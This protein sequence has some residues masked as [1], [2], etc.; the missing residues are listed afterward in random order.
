MTP[1]IEF[2]LLF[3]ILG[4]LILSWGAYFE[5]DVYVIFQQA[6]ALGM[7]QLKA[8]AGWKACPTSPLYML[9]LALPAALH[10]AI[11]QVALLLSVLGWTLSA[12]SL[13]RL[14]PSRA[15]AYLSVLLLITSPLIVTTLG[16]EAAWMA[17][18]TT[19]ALYAFDK[20]HEIL[21]ALALAGLLAL[22][23]NIVTVSLSL[24]LLLAQSIL[25]RQVPMQSGSIITGTLLLLGILIWQDVLPA[26]VLPTLS[27][28]P[29]RQ[30]LQQILEEST[31][32]YLFLPFICLGFLNLPRA[33]QWLGGMWSLI[34]FLDGS[35]STYT[36]LTL[37]AYCLTGRGVQTLIDALRPRVKADLSLATLTLSST[38]I[39]GGFLE[40]AHIASLQH[41]YVFRPVA[42]HQLERQ[43]ATWLWANAAP[44]GTI[45][46][47][48]HLGYY[49]GRSTL[50]SQ[51]NTRDP[52]A[53][54]ARFHA[55]NRYLPDYVIIF[56]TLDWDQ[57]LHTD[58]F[59]IGYR[60]VHTFTHAYS[61]LSPLI[62]WR[63]QHPTPVNVADPQDTHIRLPLGVEL[64]S[65][66]Y[67]P[68]RLQAGDLLYVTLLL[69]A[70]EPVSRPLH[71]IL[72]VRD[73]DGNGYAQSDILLPRQTPLDGWYPGQTI[74][75]HIVMTTSPDTPAGALTLD[76]AVM[77]PGTYTFAPLQS[78]ESTEV[79]T[80]NILFLGYLAVPW[81]NDIQP[82][83]LHPRPINANF[84]Q[85][86]SLRGL[87][88]PE[89]ITPGSHFE[90]TLYWEAQR[91]PDDNYVV[92]LHLLT[93]E[94]QMLASH[95]GQPLQSRYPTL[96]WLPS[97][98]VPDPH[99]LQL[100]SDTPPGDY[101]L[102]V[103]MYTWPDL[104]RLPVWNEQGVEIPERSL[105]LTAIQVQ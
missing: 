42:R 44:T 12:W 93:A 95:D 66:T 99:P 46:G 26:P 101:H 41:H 82:G 96:A 49:A 87:D 4:T 13:I 51:D 85:Q 84:G 17:A 10:F 18:C 8:M 57:W 68:R 3:L 50:S 29:G 33:A 21:Y 104:E 22:R 32:Y 63:S 75:T 98:I 16:S 79:N 7:G 74:A 64:L 70:T 58:A 91:P 102:Y 100:P 61:P 47:S 90:V 45:F 1:W 27:L 69:H 56:N 89:V 5:D 94:G 73:I 105:P 92:F 24:C 86:I 9:L 14:L 54:A 72:R 83:S 20:R 65:Y 43:A 23:L 76:L 88:A 55:I 67:W 2:G 77:E 39:I 6:R 80:F 35:S 30:Y 34:A 97:E 81:A 53:L 60:P 37:A 103:G 11:P 25:W 15:T 59:Q 28:Q 78:L 19:L 38:L 71:T 31:F 36:I 52:Q 48:A 62:V 40:L